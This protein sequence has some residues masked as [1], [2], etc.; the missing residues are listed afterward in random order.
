MNIENDDKHCFI[1]SLLATLH[2][3]NNDQPNRV[4][5][6]GQYFKELNIE[7]FDF[8]NGFECSDIHRFE[9]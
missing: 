8:S 2:P 3:S 9:K 4:S 7:G 5:I 1:C 6:Y